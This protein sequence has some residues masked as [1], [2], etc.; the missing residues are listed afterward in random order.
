[1]RNAA[2][3]AEL[4]RLRESRKISRRHVAADVGIT[5]EYLLKL[6]SGIAKARPGVLHELTAYYGVSVDTFSIAAD[7]SPSIRRPRAMVT[8]V[9]KFIGIAKRLADRAY[10]WQRIHERR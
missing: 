6:E 1:M 2:L 7:D 5:P 10:G 9:G 3:A 4:R 8:A